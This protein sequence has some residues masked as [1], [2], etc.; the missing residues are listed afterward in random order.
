[1]IVFTRFLIEKYFNTKFL[2][3]LALILA[4]QYEWSAYTGDVFIFRI[5]E[6]GGIKI[7]LIISGF[8]RW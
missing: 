2:Y 6:N 3:Y 4:F 7:N 1:M 8:I 5:E